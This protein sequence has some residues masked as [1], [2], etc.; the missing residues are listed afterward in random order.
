MLWARDV[1]R[2]VLA[3]ALVLEG[4]LS[5]LG[6]LQDWMLIQRSP[7][8]A[9]FAIAGVAGSAIVRILELG[10]RLGSTNLPPNLRWPVAGGYA[11]LAAAAIVWLRA[12]R[13]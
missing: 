4:L 7:P 11:V 12:Q 9:A 1:I 2:T 3:G 5:A 6:M 8:A 10:F 13:R